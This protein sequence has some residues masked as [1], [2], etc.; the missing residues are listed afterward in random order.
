[1][2]PKTIVVLEHC[3]NVGIVRGIERAHKHVDNPTQE[4]IAGAVAS[5]I[6]DELYDWF[7][8]PVQE[9]SPE[10]E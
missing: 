2:K 5:A 4:Q 8:F 7:N 1:M 10:I 6:W 9:D 3:I